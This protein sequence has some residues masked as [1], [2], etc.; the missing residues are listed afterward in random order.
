MSG[1]SVSRADLLVLP[2]LGLTGSV[3]VKSGDAELGVDLAERA[4]R[5]TSSR[6]HL[7]RGSRVTL[8]SIVVLWRRM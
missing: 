4:I 6:Q 8:E 2:G 7:V 5:A 1:D 3:T